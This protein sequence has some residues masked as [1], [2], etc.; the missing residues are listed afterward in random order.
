MPHPSTSPDINPI[1][2]C[3]RWIKQALHRRK[4][5]PTTVQE[6]EAAVTKEWEKIPQ[7]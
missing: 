7:D 4:H 5:Q 1:K 6:I 2:K 3:W